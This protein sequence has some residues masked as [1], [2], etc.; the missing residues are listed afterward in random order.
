MARSVGHTPGI[1]QLGTK[2]FAL[3]AVSVVTEN[4]VLTRS[5]NVH[6]GCSELG[7]QVAISTDLPTKAFYILVSYK[8]IKAE[9]LW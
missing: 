5:C 3:S 1:P 4:R 7:V 2:L 6:L 8:P 9:A